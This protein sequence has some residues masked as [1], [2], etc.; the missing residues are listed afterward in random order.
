VSDRQTDRQTSTVL[1]ETNYLQFIR[2]RRKLRDTDKGSTIDD[3]NELR[4]ADDVS[5]LMGADSDVYVNTGFPGLFT[6]E[7]ATYTDDITIA[8]SI[9]FTEIIK[10]IQS[11]NVEV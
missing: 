6:R 7:P 9:L 1:R 4:G 10:T 2:L 3:K 8:Y 5:W 11:F